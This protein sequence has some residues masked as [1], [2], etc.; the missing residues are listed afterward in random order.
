MTEGWLSPEEYV[1]ALPKAV[2][3]AS[4]FFTDEHD[5]PVHLHSIYS[6]EHPWQWPGGTTEAG[7]RPWQT[8]VGETAEGTGLVM[9]GP[10]RLLAAVFSLP[11]PEFPSSTVTFVFDGGQLT[12]KQLANIVLAP[13]EHDE[14]RAMPLEQWRA[15]MPV[16]DFDRHAEEAAR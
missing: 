1:A 12:G 14:V 3:S 11:G 2:V 6:P 15:L 4:V 8:A 9:S 16:G 5:R 13:E 10:P 7:E